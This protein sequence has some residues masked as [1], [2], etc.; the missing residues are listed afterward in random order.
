MVHP[1][2]DLIRISFCRENAPLVAV[3]LPLLLRPYPLT[4]KGIRA[5]Y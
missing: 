4:N 2:I 5:Q 3:R 1:V